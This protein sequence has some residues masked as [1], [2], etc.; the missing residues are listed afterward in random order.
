MERKLNIG[1][2]SDDVIFDLRKYQL[3]KG[4]EFFKKIALFNKKYKNIEVDITSYDFEG[5]FHC[6][7][8]MRNLFWLTHIKDYALNCELIPGALEKITKWKEEGHKVY[9]ITAR[10]GTTYR[11]IWGNINRHWSNKRFEELGIEFDGTDFCDEKLSARD[12]TIAAEKRRIDY[13][14]E[15]KVDNISALSK[16]NDLTVIKVLRPHNKD[17]VND[18][19]LVAKDFYEGDNYINEK[20]KFYDKKNRTEEQ[21]AKDKYE[22][23]K[24]KIKNLKYD[25][26]L[27]EKQ[28][29]N[30]RLF[31]RSIVPTMKKIYNINIINKENIPYQQGAIIISNHLHYMD[32]FV[33]Y[34]ALGERPGHFVIAKELLENSLKNFIYGNSGCV[35]LDRSDSGDRLKAFKE[36]IKYPSIDKDLV[37]FPE[38]GRNKDRTDLLKPFDENNAGVAMAAIITGAPIYPLTINDNYGRFKNDF[39]VLAGEPIIIKPNVDHVKAF[40]EVY[41]D[42]LYRM[43]EENI[44]LQNAKKEGK[45]IDEIIE[46]INKNK[47]LRGIIPGEIRYITK[48]SS[49]NFVEKYIHKDGRNFEDMTK[50]EE[51]IEELEEKAI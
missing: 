42:V 43:V 8:A 6:S 5:M 48:E 4:K 20:E 44:M 23:Q 17:Y 15:D 30:F 21:K 40:Y 12:K 41:Y 27:I 28:E 26:K 22:L 34:D 36:L 2:D 29:N 10:H 49:E 47:R 39:Y 35:A 19:V 9:N 18:K 16:V 7:K 11:N 38:G 50:K 13:F 33:F 14:F 24:N 31:Y 1:L 46:E 37:I 32:Q 51:E 45:S 3:E 25:K